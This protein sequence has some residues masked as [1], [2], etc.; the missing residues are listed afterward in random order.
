[1]GRIV[2]LQKWEK[3]HRISFVLAPWRPAGGDCADE[4]WTLVV[5]EQ[6][7]GG[8]GFLSPGPLLVRGGVHSGGA[9]RADGAGVGAGAACRRGLRLAAAGAGFAVRAMDCAAFRRPV[10]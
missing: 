5:I 1:M 10:V 4:E 8:G 9:G 3:A 6:T 2:P 7:P